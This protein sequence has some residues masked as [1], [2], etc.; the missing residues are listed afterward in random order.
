M[1]TALIIFLCLTACTKQETT[2]SMTLRLDGKQYHIPAVTATGENNCG[3][4]TYT[5][6]GYH[7]ERFFKLEFTDKDYLLPGTF[8]M[9]ATPTTERGT[10]T[11]WTTEGGVSYTARPFTVTVLTYDR[12]LLTA[13]FEG[14][15]ITNGFVHTKIS[16]R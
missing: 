8:R 5:I 3:N 15:R 16:E 6:S 4:R 1:K 11:F 9:G 14:G 10:A 12:H 2:P 7:H 13:R